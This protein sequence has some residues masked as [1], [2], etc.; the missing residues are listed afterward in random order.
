MSSPTWGEVVPIS[1]P[2]MEKIELLNQLIM[3]KKLT[4]VKSNWLYYITILETIYLRAKNVFDRIF[5]IFNYVRAKKKRCFFK[6]YLQTIRLQIYIFNLYINNQ[7][8]ILNNLQEL[9]CYK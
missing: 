1:I 3:G 7:D 5:E 8:L 6:M 2:P 9:I 4:D